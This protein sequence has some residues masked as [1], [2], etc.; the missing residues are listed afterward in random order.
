MAQTI[1]EGVAQALR[2]RG[3]GTGRVPLSILPIDVYGAAER[4]TT[5]DVARGIAEALTRHANVINLSLAS[6]TDSP[7]VRDLVRDAT[8]RGVL[9]FGAAGNE[10]VDTPTY[11]AAYPTTIAVSAS[12]GEGAIAPWANRGSFIDAIAPGTNVFHFADRDWLG[13]GTSVSTGWVSGWAAGFMTSRSRPSA[14][15]VKGATVERWG[16]PKR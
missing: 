8:A 10:P 11:P 12:D 6:D 7:L 14:G 4:T 13:T 1:L 16:L 3:D 15:A 5:F 9:V 2:E